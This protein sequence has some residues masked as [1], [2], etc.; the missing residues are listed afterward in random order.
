MNNNNNVTI[1]VYAYVDI[2]ECLANNGNCGQNCIN[3]AGSYYCTCNTGY[4]LLS[5]K[6]RCG[7]T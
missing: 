6:H 7:G 1:N 4:Q 5:D 3:T 2:N